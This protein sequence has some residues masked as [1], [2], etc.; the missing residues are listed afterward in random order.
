MLGPVMRFISAARW[1]VLLANPWGCAEGRGEQRLE[2][3]WKRLRGELID[4]QRAAHIPN[5]ERINELT[6]NMLG[7]TKEGHEL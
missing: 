7:D 2:A 4:W 6:I 3:G 5:N 1:R